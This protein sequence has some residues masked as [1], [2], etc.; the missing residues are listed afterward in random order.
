MV[1][2]QWFSVAMSGYASTKGKPMSNNDKKYKRNIEINQ[3]IPQ[4]PDIIQ[5]K[6]LKLAIM[7]NMRNKIW[8][9]PEYSAYFRYICRLCLYKMENYAKHYKKLRTKTY[10]LCLYKMDNYLNMT[11]KNIKYSR[12]SADSRYIQVIP[13]ITSLIWLNFGY[14]EALGGILENVV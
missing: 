11:Q 6:L 4:I 7:K 1:I 13:S 9:M 8:N 14:P 2:C 10:R 5:V 12:Y 3:S